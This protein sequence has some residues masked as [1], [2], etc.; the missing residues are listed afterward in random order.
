[1]K[2]KATAPN[3]QVDLLAIQDS[4]EKLGKDMPS[5]NGKE[6]ILKLGP[7]KGLTGPDGHPKNKTAQNF[8]KLCLKAFRRGQRNA[9]KLKT[10]PAPRRKSVKLQKTGA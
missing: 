3:Q 5:W 4:F 6:A 2:R 9:K 7:A 10:I 8:L 1:M